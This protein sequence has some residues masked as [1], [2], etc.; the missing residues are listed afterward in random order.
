VK[1]KRRKKKK[2][3]GKQNKKGVTKD[4]SDENGGEE[5]TV[6]TPVATARRVEMDLDDEWADQAFVPS[7]STHTSEPLAKRRASA[8]E[9]QVP[10]VIP[11]VSAAVI[12]LGHEETILKV[13]SL[14][15]V[16][17]N[18]HLT[19]SLDFKTVILHSY[20]GGFWKGMILSG[21]AAGQHVEV[22]SINLH[23]QIGTVP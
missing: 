12:G 9:Q 6:A 22:L 10:A 13:G 18:L 1:P 23:G 8:A 2:T 14:A 4:N 7:D 17:N 5:K 19:Q 21:P 16:V 11:G 15:D 3:K 20:T